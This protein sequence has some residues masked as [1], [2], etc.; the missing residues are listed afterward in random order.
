MDSLKFLRD[1][2]Y[3]YKR[4][5][6][7]FWGVYNKIKLN[8]LQVEYGEKCIIHGHL[9]MDISR[10]AEIKI[11][12][13]FCFLGG[14]S[15][16]PIS[17]NIVGCIKINENGSL[18]IG[19]NVNISSACIWAHKSIKIGN[20]VN[21]GA[22]V[23]IMDSDAHSLNYRYRRDIVKDMQNKIDEPIIIGNDVLIGANSIILKGVKIGDRSI[24]G[25][26]SVVTKEIPSDSISCGSPAKV[27]R[28]I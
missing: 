12:K 14:R 13:N 7:Q 10:T 15:L 17:R 26:G 9:S 11:G 28:H 27:V 6:N 21:I 16:N 23:I 20:N 1:T 24:I 25:A 3:T 18:I 5:T 19:D 2:T 22:N 4:I 8:F